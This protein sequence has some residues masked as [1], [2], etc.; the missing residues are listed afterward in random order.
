MAWAFANA[1]QSDAE[2]FAVLSRSAE[3]RA[4]ALSMLE[5]ASTMWA[6]ATVERA[7]EQLCAVL[8]G[9]AKRHTRF[10]AEHIAM[11]LWGLSQHG[12]LKDSWSLFDTARATSSSRSLGFEASSTERA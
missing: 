1:A 8:A 7:D 4:H 3:S 10:D 6:F 9:A 12:S 2:L 5:L 11:A